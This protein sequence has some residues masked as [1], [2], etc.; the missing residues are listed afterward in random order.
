[1]WWVPGRHV[2]ESDHL[3]IVSAVIENP[4]FDPAR[5][6]LVLLPLVLLI[7][8]VRRRG[9]GISD[10]LIMLGRRRKHRLDHKAIHDNHGHVSLGERV[11]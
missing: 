3:H 9:N 1:M 10:E 4:V 8:C 5:Q 2:V 7:G 6:A 11:V